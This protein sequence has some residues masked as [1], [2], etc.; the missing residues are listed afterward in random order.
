[1]RKQETERIKG[2]NHS[3]YKMLVLDIDGTL[4]NSRKEITPAT[5]TALLQLQKNGVYVAI[6][7]GRPT[8]GVRATAAA[9]ELERFSNYVLSYNGACITNWGTR[10]IIAQQTLPAHLIPDIF[11]S[12]L[13]E[14]A[15]IISYEGDGVIAGTPIDEYME[16]EARINGIPIRYIDNFAEYITF[17]V[18]KCLM[19]GKPEHMAEVEK[20]LARK[21]EGI[22]N[23][24]RSEPFFLEMMPCG[25]DK[26]NS[27]EK[28]LRHL[29]LSRDEMVC[30]G[31]GYNDI[32]M[33]RYAGLGVA[34]KNAQP[35]VQESA[36]YITASNDEDGIVQVIEQFF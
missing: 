4:T 26:A 15:G 19:T 11:Q 33:L 32:S 18:N 13:T 5:R 20:A 8:P 24:Y 35:A 10:E 29:G 36:D 2:M 1:M 23:V 28:L 21:Y 17:P 31:D 6:A 12:A 9:L 27:L 30:C 25:V 16:L 22:L 3:K 14:H 7:S 34:M